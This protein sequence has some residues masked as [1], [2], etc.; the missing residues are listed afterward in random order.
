M[1]RILYSIEAL[2]EVGLQD[3][4]MEGWMWLGHFIA[5]L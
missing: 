1:V 5:S 3:M 2:L 4:D